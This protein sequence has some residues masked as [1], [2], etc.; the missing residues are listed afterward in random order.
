[1]RSWKRIFVMLSVALVAASSAQAQAP[2]ARS[3]LAEN[4]A[5]QYW[6]AFAQMPT[7]NKDDEK[8]L[9]EWNTVAIDGPAVQRLIAGSHASLMYLHRAA[10]LKRCD[11]GL[12]YSDGIAMMIPHVEKSRDLARIAALHARNHIQQGNRKAFRDDVTAI[13]TLARHIGRDPLLI[14]ILVR[15]LI[16]DVAIDLIAPHVP[17][18]KVPHIE[19]AGM[20]E[21]LPKGAT[22]VETIP[23]EKKHMAG[24]VIRELMRLERE[25]KDSWREPWKQMMGSHAP[26][27]VK[28]VATLEE[29]VKMT[30]DLLPYYDE[31]EKILALPK[32][33]FDAKYSD[34]KR[35]AE[36][37]T[38]MAAFLLPAID[39]FMT[40]E[41]RNQA[42]FAL[43]FA[44]FAVAQE[45]PDK[46]K[47]IK[48]PFG[49]GPF[50][51]RALDQGFELKSK[52]LFED[53]PVTLTV[54]QRKK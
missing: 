44:A 4:A 32:K 14:S 40:K 37:A 53:K 20:Y 28:N 38:P 23:I 18:M 7:L 30:E 21:A 22:V 52:L 31:L 35:K 17:E 10:K 27:A 47:D 15:Y 5:I 1:M 43:L 19:V 36:A 48:D 12:D 3:D 11:W 51:Y 49:D 2:D 26:D 16:E 45:G 25:R 33:E 41:R 50:E 6:Q 54:G 39:K 24:Y 8:I 34:L 13:M 42:R 9:A 29:A 46:L